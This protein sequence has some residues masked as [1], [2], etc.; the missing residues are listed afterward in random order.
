MHILVGFAILQTGAFFALQVAF[1][2]G[3][4]GIVVIVLCHYSEVS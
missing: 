4:V 1:G 3:V 2:L